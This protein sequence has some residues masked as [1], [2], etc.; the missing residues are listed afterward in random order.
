M[1][2]MSLLADSKYAK[3]EMMFDRLKRHRISVNQFHMLLILASQG[4]S[5]IGMKDMVSYMQKKRGG[6]ISQSGVSRAINTLGD[7]KDSWKE[8]KKDKSITHFE[9]DRMQGHDFLETRTDEKDSRFILFRLN[10]RGFA[11]IDKTLNI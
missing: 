11:F 6:R 10:R 5:W 9:Q 3:Y 1:L 4:N 8:Q 7:I 2:L